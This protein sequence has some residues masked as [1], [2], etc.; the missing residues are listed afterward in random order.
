MV[1]GFA[2]IDTSGE[3]LEIAPD[4]PDAWR[5]VKFEFMWKGETILVEIAPNTLQLSKNT[6][7]MLELVIYG[8]KQQL[9]DTLTIKMEQKD[10]SL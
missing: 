7:S 2:G 3:L 9:T 4:L 6:K 5:F 1:F 8:E 10:V